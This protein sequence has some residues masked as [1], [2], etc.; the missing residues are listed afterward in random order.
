[1]DYKLAE[2]LRECGM[3]PEE[4][5]ARPEKIPTKIRHRLPTQHVNDLLEGKLPDAGFGLGANVGAGK[6]QCLASLI[7]MWAEARHERYGFP[8]SDTLFWV[9]WTS[10]ANVIRKNPVNKGLGD[11][12][13]ERASNVEL[14]VL[15]D[16]GSEPM[17]G[18][19]AEDYPA[20]Q[21]S[22]VINQRYRQNKSMLWSTNLTALELSRRYGPRFASRLLGRWPLI[23]VPDMPDLRLS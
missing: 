5:N 2:A 21:L 11:L 8:N 20:T 19:F 17:K 12:A 18:T 15:D 4:L 13:I 22:L 1:M 16:L 6:T 14:L 23:W 7:L 9:P 3:E 10:T